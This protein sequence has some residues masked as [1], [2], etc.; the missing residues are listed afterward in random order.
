MAVRYFASAADLRAWLAE[1]HGS[2]V[3]LWVGFYKKG[4]GRASVTYAECVDEML[5]FGWIDGVRKSVDG[6]RYTVRCTPR[7]TKSYWSVVN[8]RRYAELDRRGRVAPAGRAAFARREERTG[9]YSFENRP[10]RLPPA[11][12]KAFRADE[13]AWAFFAAQPPGYRRLA[14]WW[15]VS[16]AREETR[17]R[18]LAA[19]IAE[20]RRGR[21]VGARPKPE[22]A[23]KKSGR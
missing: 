10:R 22:S 12:A 14:A 9:R 1:H 21:R 18:R 8:R 4:T 11:Y 16:A 15:I 3:E 7:K 2:A 13:K 5:C 23:K 19:L 17:A 20:S 6:E